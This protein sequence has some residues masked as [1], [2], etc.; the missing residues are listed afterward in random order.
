MKKTFRTALVAVM[1]VALVSEPTFGRGGG[2]RGGGGFHGG[3]GFGGGGFGGGGGGAAGFGGGARAGGFGG[4]EFGGARP[5]GGLGGDFGGGQYGGDRFGGG[6][7]HSGSF[8]SP[9]ARPET[10]YPSRVGAGTSQFGVGGFQYHANDLGRVVGGNLGGN[11]GGGNLGDRTNIGDRA[12]IG[13]RTNLGDRVNLGDRANLGNR[14]GNFDRNNINRGNFN[15][16]NINVNRNNWNNNHINHGNWYHGNWNG[17]WNNG[18]RYRPYGWWGGYGWG[19]GAGLAASSLIPWGWGYWGYSN[20]YATGSY[21]ANNTTINYAEPL[22]TYGD[23]AQPTDQQAGQ[24]NADQASAAF[25]DARKSF[26]DE[27]Y[28][29]AL[30]QVDSAIGLTPDDPV[31]HE[32][33]GLVLFATGKYQQAAAAVYAVLS[34]GPGWDWTTLSSLYTNP[35]LFTRQLRALE[36]YCKAHPDEAD[37][38]FLLAYEYMTMGSTDGAIAELKQVVKINP[39]D[40]LSQQL[41]TSLTTPADAKPPTPD[42]P[43]APSTPVTAAQLAGDWKYKRADGGSIELDITDGSKYTWSYTHQGKTESHTGT[44]SVAD[45]LLVLNTDDAP[46]MVGQVSGVSGDSFH[47]KLAGGSPADPGL[48]F[49]K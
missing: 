40:T 41:L 45:N 16:D 38:A 18:W 3:G 19:F 48:T 43:A 26:A 11:V 2:G 42:E 29:A 24:S 17:H 28:A 34:T 32:F 35:D 4:G 30:Q 10:F 49:S 44:Y 12:N 46:A 1:L 33:R 47:F 37:A 9:S 21:V 25:A 8:N 15:R 27:D 39:K 13:G 6:L 36:S 14:T 22:A 23:G 31:L 5:G 7:S 20:P